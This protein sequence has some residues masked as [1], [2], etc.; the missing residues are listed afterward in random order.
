MLLIRD[1][2][3]FKEAEQTIRFFAYHDPLTKIPNRRN[4]YERAGQAILEQDS[5]TVVVVDLDG[6]KSINDTYGHQIGDAFLIHLAQLL[7]RTVKP[8]GF[9]A[10]VGGDEFFLMNSFY[11]CRIR[12][13]TSCTSS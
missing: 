8:P 6:F 7:E 2:Q 4:F 10:R 9:A 3:S 12:H 11:C 1:I 13:R 5:V